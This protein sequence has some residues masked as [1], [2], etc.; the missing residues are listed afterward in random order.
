[1][2]ICVAITEAS[3]PNVHIHM[4]TCTLPTANSLVHNRLKQKCLYIN[5]THNELHQS[6]TEHLLPTYQ[7]YMGT[8]PQ[9]R[10][11]SCLSK[12]KT[13]LVHFIHCWCLNT[14]L[15]KHI[16]RQAW[17]GVILAGYN[18]SYWS[19]EWAGTGKGDKRKAKG[20]MRSLWKNGFI[21]HGAV[22]R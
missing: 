15:E 7:Q 17:I 10:S 2:T 12:G 18:I 11:Y 16:S 6:S 3:S 14:D 1:M 20:A 22:K 5:T 8:K 19:Y 9:C 4:H 21:L 13:Q